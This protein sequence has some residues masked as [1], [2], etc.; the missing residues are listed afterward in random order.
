MHVGIEG[1]L[2]AD[3]FELDPVRDA[4]LA[5]A[6]R[7]ADRFVGGVA[8]GGVRQQEV[9]LGIDIVE[10]RFLTAVEIDAT[11][12]DRDHVGATDFESASGFLK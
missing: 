5:A 7:R 11:H 1:G 3:N 2:V 6:P 9:L 10:H 12:R 8:A 4:N